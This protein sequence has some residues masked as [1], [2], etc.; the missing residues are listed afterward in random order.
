MSDDVRDVLRS[1]CTQW[2]A[3]A[4]RFTAEAELTH[5]GADIVRL[6]SV[7]VT[8]EWAA[9][10]LSFHLDDQRFAQGSSDTPAQK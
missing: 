6:T 2:R 1:L 7:A 3:R 10:D 8:L 4:N 9:R 5:R